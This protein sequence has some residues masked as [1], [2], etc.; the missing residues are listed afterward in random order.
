MKEA[1]HMTKY[2]MISFVCH[3]KKDKT[4]LWWKK[5]RIVI[6]SVGRGWALTGKGHE[7]MINFKKLECLPCARP[8]L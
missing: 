8:E 3:T 5:I 6:D 4:N 7:G 1:I 2:C